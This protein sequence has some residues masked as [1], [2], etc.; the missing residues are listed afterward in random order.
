MTEEQVL[1]L[2]ASSQRAWTA[3]EIVDQLAERQFRVA[4][5]QVYR[6]LARLCALGQVRRIESQNAYAYGSEAGLV[7][8][9]CRQCKACDTV[10]ATE[11]AKWI[12]ARARDAGFEAERVVLELW[13][14]C[15]RCGKQAVAAALLLLCIVLPVSGEALACPYH[16]LGGAQ[17]FGPFDT[18]GAWRGGWAGDQTQPFDTGPTATQPPE[19]QKTSEYTRELEDKTLREKSKRGRA[20]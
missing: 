2:L 4:P 16:S 3:Y 6:A 20:E 13:G 11:L 8:L 18:A 17:R 14:L 19:P 12:Q 5:A 10:E 9:L 7:S 1:A 15:A